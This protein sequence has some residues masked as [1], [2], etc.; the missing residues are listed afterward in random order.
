MPA[1]PAIPTLTTER[2]RLRAFRDDDAPALA[3]MNADPEVMAWMSRALDRAQSDGFLRRIREHWVADGFGLWAVERIQDGAFLGFGGL[4][5]PAFEAPFGPAV[6]VGW[7]L[8]RHAWGRGYATEAGAAA[9]RYGFEVLGLEEIVSFTAVGNVRS[10]RVMEKLG[11]THDPADDFEYPLVPPDH[12]VRR[13]V[14]YRI[15]RERWFAGRTAGATRSQPRD[16]A[17]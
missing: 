5:P 12:K 2:L 15:P 14:L 10:R 7:R 6:E 8:A 4:A 13:Q 17:R 3:A 11:L 16:G 1:V 9:V